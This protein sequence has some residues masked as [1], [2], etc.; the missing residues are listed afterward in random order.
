MDSR[1]EREQL[2]T[3]VSSQRARYSI[4]SN[5]AVDYGSIGTGRFF[6]LRFFCGAGVQVDGRHGHS[7]FHQL[8]AP[9]VLI[10]SVCAVSHHSSFKRPTPHPLTNWLLESQC[11]WF[12][13]CGFASVF[14]PHNFGTPTKKLVF[15]FSMLRSL[16]PGCP[17][18]MT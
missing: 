9:I 11:F 16:F 2:K 10:V 17:G 13:M 12:W 4:V 1:M 7:V 3:A 8:T 18:G 5:T 6:S 15:S 14:N